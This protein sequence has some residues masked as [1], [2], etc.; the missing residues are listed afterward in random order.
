MKPTYATEN[1]DTQQI[2]PSPFQKRKHFVKEKLQDLAASIE[3]DGQIEPIIIIRPKA[4]RY[5]LIAGERRL[6][7][8]SLYTTLKTI[9]AKVIDVIQKKWIIF[10][11][12]RKYPLPLI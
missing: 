12:N 7:A 6:R 5:E 11:N 3:N 1:I 2:N 10:V 9:Q 4:G 8:I